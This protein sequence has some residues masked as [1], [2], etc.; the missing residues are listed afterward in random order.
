MK[1]FSKE[2]LKW[3]IKRHPLLYYARYIL[4]SKNYKGKNP[5]AAGCYNDI[6]LSPDI[7]KLYF[8]TNTQIPLE[9][10]MP[11]FEKAIAIATYLRTH[12]K[13]GPGLSLS[14]EKTLR[15]MLNG[16]GGVCNDFSQI[17]NNFCVINS[18]LVKEWNCVHNFFQ[19]EYGHT[20]NEIYSPEWNKW[21]AIDV[22][23]AFYFT[24]ENDD[25][26]L[27]AIEAFTR[28]RN[29]QRN[30]FRFFIPGYEPKSLD[31]LNKIYAQTTIPFLTIN[32]QNSV[33][34][35]YLDKFSDRYPV[36]VITTMMILLRKN[37]GFLFVL[38]NYRMKLLPKYFQKLAAK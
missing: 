6:N 11:A 9:P 23:Q 12:I 38:D 22:H 1:L 30:A 16:N 36:F 18:I 26:P 33:V 17:F 31:R 28:L 37:F 4:L 10:N 7:P 29:N 15:A 21:I 20:F 25:Q 27:S 32:Y 19:T 13:G 34:D 2:K 5:E 3:M 24:A 14:S 35:K 8:D